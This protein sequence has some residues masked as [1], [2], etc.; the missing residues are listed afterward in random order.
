M[1]LSSDGEL[2]LRFVAFTTARFQR[3][4]QSGG[5]MKGSEQELF[6]IIG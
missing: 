3:R 4:Q 5:I 2:R 1:R 6:K